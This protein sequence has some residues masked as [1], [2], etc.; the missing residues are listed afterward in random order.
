MVWLGLCRATSWSLPSGAANG[1]DNHFRTICRFAIADNGHKSLNAHIQEC[2]V[3]RAQLRVTDG[4]YSPP[5]RRG[6][7]HLD[8]TANATIAILS[9][10]TV[11][12]GMLV[13]IYRWYVI[14][15]QAQ[16]VED[17]DVPLVS[18]GANLVG[19]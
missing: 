15:K 3:P 14:R 10:T 2:V 19:H 4:C 11:I 13:G 12:P 1:L 16:S 5:P 8:D 17:Q 9:L 18:T 7:F 6:P